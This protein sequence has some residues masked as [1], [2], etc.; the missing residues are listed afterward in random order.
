MKSKSIRES[1]LINQDSYTKVSDN[2]K[3]IFFRNDDVGLFS[4]EPVS[5][6]LINL[7]Q[8]FVEENIPVSHSI[9]PAAV[10]IETVKWL[11]DMKSRYPHLIGIDQHGY[12]HISHGAGEFGGKRSYGEQKQDIAAGL[13]LMNR[14]FGS[15]FSHCFCVPKIRYNVHTKK[16]CDEMGFKVF[17][18]GVSPRISAQVFNMLGRA[19][20]LNVLGPKEISYHRRADFTQRGFNIMEISVSVDVVQD[21]KTRMVKTIDTILNRYNQCE[22]YFDVIGFMLHHWV[23]DSEYKLAILRGLLKALRKDSFVK[24]RLL[25]NVFEEYY[26]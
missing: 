20:N 8:V 14:Y 7:T 13:V 15:A 2:R 11:L 6:E 22:K 3:V 9:V 26:W 17:S 19:M 18:G 21:Y 12:A 1:P 24:F 5:S 4:S 10:N 23:F 16:I 25:E